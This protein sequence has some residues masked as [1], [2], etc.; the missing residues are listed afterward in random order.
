MNDSSC[1]VTPYDAT[2][3]QTLRD[4]AVRRREA[5]PAAQRAALE[6]RIEAHL[7]A[8]CADL[9]PQVLA[10]CW[11][12][13]AEPDLR[14]WV[15]RWLSAAPGRCA[16]LPV[17]LERHQPL[18]FR[19]WLPG[20]QMELDRHGIPHPPAGAALRPDLVLV[21]LNAFD[22]AGFRLG[23]GGGYFDRTL[24]ALPTVAAGV[25]F[26]LGRTASVLPQA[27]DR[28]MDWLVTEAGLFRAGGTAPAG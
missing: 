18:V 23:Y 2:L 25:G 11:P 21:P 24:A 27:H 3:R 28:P 9:A 7:D 14:P 16:A 1:A 13:R 12:W 19:R 17:V 15:T 22:A 20:M 5:L 26:E 6:G 10:F 8:L 4:E